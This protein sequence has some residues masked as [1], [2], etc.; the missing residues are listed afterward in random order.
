MP[1]S[2]GTSESV[3]SRQTPKAVSMHKRAFTTVA[4]ITRRTTSEIFNP[5]NPEFPFTFFHEIITEITSRFSPSFFPSCFQGWDVPK[6]QRQLQL[7][8]LVGHRPQGYSLIT[9]ILSI[10]YQYL[11][12]TLIKIIN[13]EL[14]KQ[15]V[16][17]HIGKY[18]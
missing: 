3:N 7:C 12:S 9:T 11:I 13:T 17:I 4:S 1:L 18:R 5:S 16:E 14:S 2:F 15:D 10:F 6:T 8:Q